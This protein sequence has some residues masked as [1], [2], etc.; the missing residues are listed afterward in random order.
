M[1][2]ITLLLLIGA[3]FLA[4][5]TWVFLSR[6]KNSKAVNLKF[7]LGGLL[8]TTMTT[9]STGCNPPT[10][11]EPSCYEPPTCY[12]PPYDEPSKA[13]DFTE[14]LQGTDYIVFNLNNE[15]VFDAIRNNVALD[16]R[17]DGECIMQFE[18]NSGCYNEAVGVDAWGATGWESIG[19]GGDWSGVCSWIGTN[20]DDV[21]NEEEIDI[22]LSRYLELMQDE[23]NY[24]LVVVMKCDSEEANPWFSVGG[25]GENST[26]PNV[27]QT[28]EISS[29]EHNEDDIYTDDNGEKQIHY[30]N[31][32]RDGQW[33]IYKLPVSRLHGFD[34]NSFFREVDG[35]IRVGASLFARGAN[36]DYS[37]DICAAFLCKLP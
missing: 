15:V 25:F 6:G 32:A 23:Y 19:K 2:K 24:T 18:W 13:E 9:L 12:E 28:F 5:S 17:P 30:T 1:K 14:I 11:Y 16:L 31:I 4:V 37:C 35:V 20:V 26:V 33:H 3:A 22:K 8:L 29:N 7:K 10:C 36:A 27:V 21:V 34:Y